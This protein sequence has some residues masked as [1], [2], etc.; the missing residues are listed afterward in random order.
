MQSRGPVLDVAF[1]AIYHLTVPFSFRIS[2]IIHCL[3]LKLDDLTV[4]FAKRAKTGK[5]VIEKQ[6]T[7]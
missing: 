7:Q 4:S 1:S 3:L 5:Q 6:V 2:Y